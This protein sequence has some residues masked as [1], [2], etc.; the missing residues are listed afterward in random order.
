MAQKQKLKTS[1]V[2]SNR[3]RKFRRESQLG[4]KQAVFLMGLKSVAALSR[5]ENGLRTPNLKNLF[6]LEL[7]LG[8]PAR[9][10]YPDLATHVAKE[11]RLRREKLSH[12]VHR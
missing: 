8:V 1:D 10:L 4:Q 6:A 11:I 7:T 3:I 2:F 5:Y 9:R 12:A